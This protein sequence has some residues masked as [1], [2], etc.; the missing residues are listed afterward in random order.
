MVC[1]FARGG[2]LTE[3]RLS[4]RP[5]RFF[6]GTCHEELVGNLYY[7]TAIAR[8]IYRRYPASLSEELPWRNWPIFGSVITT[9]LGRVRKKPLSRV[10]EP[11]AE[12][13]LDEF[14][15]VWYIPG[16]IENVPW[17][18]FFMSKGEAQANTVRVQKVTEADLPLSL[19]DGRHAV[20][21]CASQSILTHTSFGPR[22][23]SLLRHRVSSG[24]RA[25]PVRNTEN[26]LVVGPSWVGDMV[27][28]QALFM[29]LKKQDPSVTSTLWRLRGHALFGTDA[30]GSPYSE[31][32]F[33]SWRTQPSRTL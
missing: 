6:G 10:M 21:G 7:A 5:G 19:S 13:T 28:A 27:M 30:G 33:S 8:Q 31:L 4:A 16:L 32:A 22:G 24:N 11:E 3:K 1:L 29:A 18:E 23:L 12:R 9:P 14:L 2:A 25:L 20:V 17:G 15:L 26:I